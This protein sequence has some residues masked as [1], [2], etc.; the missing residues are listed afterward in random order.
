MTP[1][2]YKERLRGIVKLAA[3]TV[4]NSIKRMK[5]EKDRTFDIMEEIL[6]TASEIILS[7]SMGEDS[8]TWEIFGK[9]VSV[10]KETLLLS[11][12]TLQH[13]ILSEL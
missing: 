10:A 3:A 5:V 9:T 11:F 7:C 8:S 4:K 12:G 13:D 6:K 2:F 1:A